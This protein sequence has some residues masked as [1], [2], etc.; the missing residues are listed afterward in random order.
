[1]KILNGSRHTLV[2]LTLASLLGWQGLPSLAHTD[3]VEL[4]AYNIDL[5]QTSVSGISS[6]AFM[7]VQMHAAHA[8]SIVGVGVF[9]GG[10]YQCA[11]TGT[12]SQNVLGALNI[13]MAGK[14]SASDSID[15]LKSAEAANE[16]A[17]L[18]D[19]KSDKIW[20]YSGY[21]DGVVKQPTMDQLDA[22]YRQLVNSGN[23]YYR[24]NQDAGHAQIVASGG[25][26]C[27]LN[28]GEFIN[29]CDLDGAGELLNFIYGALEPYSGTATLTATAFNQT[30]FF[31]NDVNAVMADT[32]YVYVPQSCADGASCRLHIAFHGCL[33][34]AETI[35]DAF[36]NHTGYNQWAEQNNFV[37][38]YPQTTSSDDALGAYNPKGCWDWWGYSD[39]TSLHANY[40][41]RTS[42][43]IAA[44]WAMAQQLASA[45]SPDDPNAATPSSMPSPVLLNAADASDNEVSLVWN[46]TVGM[47]YDVKQ[48]TSAAGPFSTITDQPVTGGSYGVS[49]LSSDTEYFFQLVSHEGNGDTQTSNIASIITG[50]AA[51]K[52]D[53]WYG[54]LTEHI[55]NSRAY[56]NLV[57]VYAMG[58]NEDIGSYSGASTE[59]ATL[60]KTGDGFWF[61]PETYEKANCAEN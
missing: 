59:D 5:S 42:K 56:T 39:P 18:A 51:A 57:R 40:A 11:G 22:Y 13:C 48:A 58:S 29:D 28:G 6:G 26:Q 47:K 43:Q 34:N 50:R 24:D 49:E 46:P 35:G 25:Q 61:W 10:P 36:Y 30:P 33:Q 8:D 12:Q 7:T 31:N 52:C 4:G 41:T 15:R 55:M 1:M 38:L 17:P 16:I 2:K 19:M 60:L 45:H 20:L 14:A 54:T 27:I 37:V 44:V 9:A 23:V 21:N 3:A 32:A 53:P